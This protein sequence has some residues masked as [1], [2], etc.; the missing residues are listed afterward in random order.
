MG[1]EANMWG[2][3]I[4]KTEHAS[5]YDTLRQWGSQYIHGKTQ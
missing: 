2:E 4:N 5:K 3:N 1:V